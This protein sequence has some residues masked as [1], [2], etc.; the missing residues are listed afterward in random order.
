[1]TERIQQKIDQITQKVSALQQN[2]TIHVDKSHR[3]SS[4]IDSLKITIEVLE[5][6]IQSKESEIKALSER[7]MVTTEQNASSSV[8]TKYQREKE[9]DDLVKEIE[10]CIGQLKK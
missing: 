3:L 6:G 2:L 7:M 5:K 9:I 4:E 8:D 1:M 10:Y